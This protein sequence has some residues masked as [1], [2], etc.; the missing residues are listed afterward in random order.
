MVEDAPECALVM[1][2]R[3]A[4]VQIV[5]AGPAD[6][7]ELLR[8][9]GATGECIAIVNAVLDDGTAA[10]LED[11][12]IA[13][14]DAGGRGWLPGRA[15]TRRRRVPDPGTPRAPR[16]GSL[17]LA[18]LL[19]DHPHESWTERG[20]AER[21]ESTQVTAHRLLTQLELRGLVERRGT[22]RGASRRVTDVRALR[23]WL[24]RYGRP[25]R[26][27]RLACFLPD[28]A[29]IAAQADPLLVLTG[30]LAAERLGLPVLTATPRATYR[31]QATGEALEQIP[32]LLGGFRTERGANAVLISD[33]ERLASADAGRLPDGQ[34]VAPPS[35]IMLDLH[36]EPRGRAAVSVFLDLWSAQTA[37]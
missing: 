36:L 26:A 12:G 24:A 27:Q 35:R 33:P 31:V 13:Y 2:G 1:A 32:P 8:A 19:A 14:V 5:V 3:V 22:G 34:A 28:A 15:R 11:A 29:P 7:D 21:G 30:A 25:G 9:R 18:Q 23:R 20:L 17:R 6:V 16:G 10:R 37:L 4:R